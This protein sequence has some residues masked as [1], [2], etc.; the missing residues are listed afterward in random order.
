MPSLFNYIQFILLGAIW[1]GSFLLLRITS[2][3]LGPFVVTDSRVL[4][5]TL[6]LGSYALLLRQ[7]IFGQHP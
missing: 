4:L 2:P 7:N 6:M 5:G 3:V 1:G